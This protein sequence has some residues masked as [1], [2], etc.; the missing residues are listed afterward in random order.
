MVKLIFHNILVS[1]FLV[2]MNK[3]RLDEHKRLFK[4]TI[5]NNG[6]EFQTFDR[7]LA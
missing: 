5:N 6:F 1:V 3:R 4:K 7:Y 2:Q